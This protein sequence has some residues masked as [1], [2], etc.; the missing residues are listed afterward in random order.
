MNKVK[1]SL[2]VYGLLS[3]HNL[4]KSMAM[5]DK[6][7]RIFSVWCKCCRKTVTSQTELKNYDAKDIKHYECTC[8]YSFLGYPA[9]KS[10]PFCAALHCH[11]WLVWLYHIFQYY[12][13]QGSIFEKINY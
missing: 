3:T 6:S 2:F 7:F 1:E 13:T 10:H 9:G 11:A 8:L 5:T 4:T 12:L